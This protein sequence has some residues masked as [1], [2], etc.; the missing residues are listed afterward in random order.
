MEEKIQ[1]E[2]L[3]VRF[4]GVTSSSLETI[5]SGKRH[6]ALQSL[7]KGYRRF[8]IIAIT[9]MILW[10][11]TVLLSHILP[12]VEGKAWL[13]VGFAIYFG[14][15]AVMDY[16]LYLGISRI[17]CAT[18]PV[19]EVAKLAAYYRKRHLTFIAIL[20]PMAFG[21]LIWMATLMHSSPAVIYGMIAG[22]I[23]GLIV[24]SIQLMKFMSAYKNL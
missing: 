4:K 2:W 10:C 15:V 5:I 22:G 14:I 19:N 1:K 7:A 12:D 11:P 21:I 23:C 13:V 3:G 16:W 17:D 20:I 18:M 24:G 6:T 9:F 8:S